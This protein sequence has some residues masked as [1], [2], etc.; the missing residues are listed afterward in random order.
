[1]ANKPLVFRFDDVEVRE[2]E[3]T[4]FRAGE[5]FPVEPKAFRVLLIL[6]RNPGKLIAKEE[7][8]NAVWGDA[9]VTDN[10]LARSVALLRRLLEDETR[11]PCYIET[12]ATVGYRFVCKVEVFEDESGNLVA[13][14]ETSANGE[15]VD[16]AAVPLPQIGKV[17]DEETKHD[18]KKDA[19]NKRLLTWVLPA[20]AIVLLCLG[21]AIWTLRRPL[22]APR[23]LRLAVSI[24]PSQGFVDTGCNSVLFTPDGSAIV[25]SGR[26][27]HDNLL[28]YRR[29]DQ[30]EGTALPGTEGGDCLAISPSGEWVA[31]ESG[32]T[33]GVGPIVSKVSVRG[34]A[35]VKIA[36]VAYE[37]GLSWGPD[38]SIYSAEGAAGLFRIPANGGPR[39]R[40]AVPDAARHE[41]GW[42]APLVLPD[43]KAV[44]AWSIL[45]PQGSI[46]VKVRI[47]DG[48]VTELDGAGKSPIGVAGGY[49]LFGRIDGTLGVVPFDSDRTR[50]VEAVIPVL[51]APLSA[52]NGMRASISQA[53]DL[54]YV[55]GLVD[56][57]MAFLDAQGHVTG[58]IRGDR[59]F[60]PH[61]PRVSPDGREIVVGEFNMDVRR[62]DLWLYD[63]VSG[64]R[65][66]LTTG[67]IATDPEWTPDGH[68]VSY[69]VVPDTSASLESW[70]TPA[71]RSGPAERFLASPFSVVRVEVSPDSR[72]AV[73]TARDLAPKDPLRAEI[74]SLPCGPERRPYTAAARTVPVREGPCEDLSRRT[75]ARVRLRRE[76][77]P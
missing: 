31:F 43:G 34:G 72:Y 40:I 77:T 20:A 75:L 32:T 1:M 4:L 2:R 39:Q 47:A 52:L 26:G 59:Y 12:V 70:W 27:P 73:V 30:L 57:H 74:R 18:L 49:L 51:D 63:V 10:S 15:A 66:R 53:G 64:T 8:L 55:K 46:L 60:D 38:D 7:L 69:S 24:P 6:L 28:Y 25:Y 42:Y 9:A 54:V 44:L 65:Q 71:H 58:E 48:E 50:S 11:S 5:A 62:E 68:R 37:G 35:A 76:R 61:G 45:K 14:G 23:V 19:G 29:L 17:A 33:S 16:S 21:A 41:S 13:S 67:V 22:P 3:F 56:S 36:E